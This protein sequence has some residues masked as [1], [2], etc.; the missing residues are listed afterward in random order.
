MLMLFIR[1]IEG[2]NGDP[3]A[4]SWIINLF[5]IFDLNIILNSNNSN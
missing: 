4:A 3:F 2:F 1:L 5:F